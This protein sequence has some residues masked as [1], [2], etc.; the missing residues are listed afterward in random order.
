MVIVIGGAGYIGFDL[1]F[2]KTILDI[3]GSR[4]AAALTRGTKFLV[5]NVSEMPNRKDLL[6]R[7]DVVINL[8]GGLDDAHLYGLGIAAMTQA[9]SN[10]SIREAC[11]DARIIHVSTQYVYSSP[12][13]NKERSKSNP[14]CDYGVV[15]AMAEKALEND[16]NAVILRFGTVWG[17]GTYTRFDTWGNHLFQLM[18]EGKYVDLNYPKHMI[19]MLSLHNAHR[20]IEWAMTA[21][22][23]LYN[24]ADCIGIREDIAK[25]ALGDCPYTNRPFSNGFSIGM[26]CN[27]IQR[28]GFT[29]EPCELGYD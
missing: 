2:E 22:P 20:A 14:A 17:K 28:K 12:E 7:F 4:S 8:V 29:F 21:D 24:V 10:L 11:P 23:G 18:E 16:D 15:Q 5:G 6:A 19:S 13:M 9:C 27:R 26:D 25:K 1:P 3:S